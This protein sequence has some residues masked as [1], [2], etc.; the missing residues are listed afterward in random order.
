MSKGGK[1]V[2]SARSA[3]RSARTMTRRDLWKSVMRKAVLMAVV[4]AVRSVGVELC[5]TRYASAEA[6]HAEARRRERPGLCD[7]DV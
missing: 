6:A 4:A 5:P 3:S 7:R 1:G 2:C